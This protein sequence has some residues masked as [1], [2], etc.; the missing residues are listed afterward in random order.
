MRSSIATRLDTF[1]PHVLSPEELRRAAMVIAV[2]AGAH[3]QAACLLTRRPETIKRHAGQFALP[4]GRVD[5]GESEA[6]AAANGPGENGPRAR[7]RGPR[8][9]PAPGH[10][11][12]PPRARGPGRGEGGG[13]CELHAPTGAILYQFREVALAGRHTR[14]G[15]FARP[16]FSWQ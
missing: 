14:V 9:G 13:S 8:P 15:Y 7:A 6:D 4:G 12:G 16:R 1:T 5:P 2:V 10:A 3:G 11:A